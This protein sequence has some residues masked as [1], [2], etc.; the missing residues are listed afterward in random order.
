[1]KLATKYKYKLMK[2]AI[3]RLRGNKQFLRKNPI[4][5]GRV[6]T[7]ANYSLFDNSEIAEFGAARKLLGRLAKKLGRKKPLMTPYSRAKLPASTEKPLNIKPK[8]KAEPPKPKAKNKHFSGRAFGRAAAAGTVGAG[9]GLL[10]E[11]GKKGGEKLV[12]AIEKR[13]NRKKK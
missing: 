3:K 11:A 7:M 4:K 10:V 6:K 8:V 13:R 1:M 5:M 2:S 9:I 12:E